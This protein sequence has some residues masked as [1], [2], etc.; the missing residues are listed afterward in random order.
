[1]LKCYHHRFLNLFYSIRLCMKLW[2]R[3]IARSTL[4]HYLNLLICLS[5]F[6][7]C[8]RYYPYIMITSSIFLL[9]TALIY[10]YIPKLLDPYTK[11]MRHYTVNLM[12]ALL[13]L[14]IAQLR[15]VWFHEKFAQKKKIEFM[16]N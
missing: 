6:F 11:L 13:L 15:Q 14:A 16:K 2:L 12:M 7:L 5:H 3:L 1:M 4:N 10:S 9:L 8:F